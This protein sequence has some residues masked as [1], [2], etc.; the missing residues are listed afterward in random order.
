MFNGLRITSTV[1]CSCFITPVPPI[2]LQFSC[3]LFL[4]YLPVICSC[5]YPPVPVPDVLEYS[6]ILPCLL[7]FLRNFFFYPPPP[8][9]HSSSSDSFLFPILSH[10]LT[11]F[12]AESSDLCSSSCRKPPPKLLQLPLLQFSCSPTPPP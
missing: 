12:C 3:L 9:P 8:S 2:I 5:V 11:C 6:V 7:S 10:S 4:L 1:S